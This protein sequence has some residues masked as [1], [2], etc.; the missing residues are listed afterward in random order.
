MIVVI[1]SWNKTEFD[2]LRE[3]LNSSKL[4][5]ETNP[6]ILWQPFN[7][8]WIVNDELKSWITLRYPDWISKTTYKIFT[9]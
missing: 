8:L 9:E 3:T 4:I 5:W 6:E 2:K 1:T 7:Q